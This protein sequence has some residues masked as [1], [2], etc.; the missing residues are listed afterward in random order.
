MLKIGI[1]TFLHN[2]NYGSTLQ[3]YALQTVLRDMGADTLHLDYRP[4]RKEKLLNLIRSRNH[5][6]LVL[7]GLRKKSVR[8][9]QAGARGKSEAIPDFYRRRMRLSPPC[10]NEAELR[11]AAGGLDLL[12]CG[13]DQIWN[14]VWL[15]RVYF[16]PFARKGQKKLAYAA[17]LGVSSLPSAGKQRRIR[18]WLRGFD[19]VSVREE[20]GAA[21]LERICGFRP[22]VLPDPVCLLT[23]EDWEALAEPP[24]DLPEA[25]LLCYFI[26]NRPD[27]WE[28]V[29]R[30]SGETGL[31]VRVVPVTGES[32]RCGF[33]LLEGLK[34]EAFLGSLHGASLVV[35]DSF[36]GL[37]LSTLLGR[38]VRVL[39]RY[40]EE[41]PESKNSR[42]DQ[43]QRQMSE[44]GAEAL[45]RE[46]LN[47]LK[48]RLEA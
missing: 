15:N 21:L 20:E 37:A 43:F 31:P 19:A 34:P 13:S 26:G 6:K 3:A 35:T 23:R 14:P 32:F 28:K 4:D 2:D 30:L 41:D 36:H 9:E 29:R 8:A 27:Y 16:L 24:A 12:I 45:R 33:P 10:R 48:S 38:E 46:G 44:K 40:R 1:L 5:P 25:Y 39:R 47:W 7:E 22:D 11:E 17:S 18:S 42:I